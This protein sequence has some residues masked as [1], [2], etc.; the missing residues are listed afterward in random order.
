MVLAPRGLR[1]REEGGLEKIEDAGERRRLLK[2]TLWVHV[3]A[4]FVGGAFTALLIALG[5]LGW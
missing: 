1:E 4:L 3:Q 2:Q 5:R